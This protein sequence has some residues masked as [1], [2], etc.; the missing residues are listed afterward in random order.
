MKSIIIAVALVAMSSSL[1]AQP[2]LVLP[3]APGAVEAARH[4]QR[5]GRNLIIAA[6][7]LQGV[8]GLLAGLSPLHPADR[9]TDWNAVLALDGV[10]AICGFTSLILIPIGIADW[11]RGARKERIALIGDAIEP[12]RAARYERAG[13]A[14][15]YTAGVLGVASLSLGML[16]F[17]HVD[18]TVESSSVTFAAGALLT[19]IGAPLAIAGHRHAHAP[20][21][22][23]LGLG[24]VRG[25]F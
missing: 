11:T 14:M 15:L 13:V 7:V 22:L 6:A 16:S 17:Y 25:T 9:P 20:V 21:Q 19:S 3:P 23:Q 10:A 18:G 2:V 24:A 5:T 4:Q 8:G 1:R 12:S